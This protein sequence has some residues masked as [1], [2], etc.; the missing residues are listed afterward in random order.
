M[1]FDFAK[2]TFG[3]LVGGLS[4]LIGL[5]RRDESDGLPARRGGG[6]A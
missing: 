1:M 4:A 6:R 2:I 3:A 5:R